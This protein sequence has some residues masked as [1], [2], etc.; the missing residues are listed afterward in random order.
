MNPTNNATN[1]DQKTV[2]LNYCCFNKEVSPLQFVKRLYIADCVV[3]LLSLGQ[4]IFQFRE[5]TWVTL[6]FNILIT[7]IIIVSTLNSLRSVPSAIAAR[8]LRDYTCCIRVGRCIY[9]GLVI[10]MALSLISFYF[11]SNRENPG[12]DPEGRVPE[13]PSVALPI[14]GF[15]MLVLS[16]LALNMACPL[17]IVVT[18]SDLEGRTAVFRNQMPG[19]SVFSG[20]GIAIG[21]HFDDQPGV[22]FQQGQRQWDAPPIQPGPQPVAYKLMQRPPVPVD[23]INI[24]NGQETN[25]FNALNG[26]NSSQKPGLSS[27]LRMGDGKN[28]I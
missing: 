2:K 12:R 24:S 1:S 13:K 10:L 20:Q 9:H 16:V 23:E 15:V 7:I 27:G 28:M 11:W 21:G 3:Y 17:S 8:R 5:M 25:P 4:L 22:I 19:P 18:A 26:P 6:L 14:Y